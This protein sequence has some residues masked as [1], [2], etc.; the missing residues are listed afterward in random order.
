MSHVS[1]HAETRDA[2][3]FFLYYIRI[4]RE[5]LYHRP[6]EANDENR[7]ASRKDF[8]SKSKRAHAKDWVSI[9]F[10]EWLNNVYK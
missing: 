10:A 7:F 9:P 8:P 3:R 2:N 5:Q 4:F 1:R 6:V